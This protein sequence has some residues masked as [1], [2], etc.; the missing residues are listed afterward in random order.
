MYW[1]FASRVE[2]FVSLCNEFENPIGSDVLAPDGLVG[3]CLNPIVTKQLTAKILKL[4]PRILKF[5]LRSL[6]NIVNE[7]DRLKAS[8]IVSPY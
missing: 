2:L 1:H 3:R 7:S 6:S 4:G 8:S 5:D